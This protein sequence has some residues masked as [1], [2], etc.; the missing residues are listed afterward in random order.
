MTTT[1]VLGASGFIGGHVAMAALEQGWEV[2]GLRR[3]PEATGHLGKA[4]IAWIQGD[5][6]EPASLVS[7]FEEVEIVFHVAGY[8]PRTSRRVAQQVARAVN[9]T[10]AVLKCAR[11]G[12]VKRFVYVSSLSTIGRPPPNETRLPDERDHYLPGSLARSAYYECKYA[13]ESEVLRWAAQGSPAL[14]VNPTAVFGPGDVHRTLGGVL[15]AIAR[16]WGVASLP[17]VINAVDVRDVAG[18]TVR[19]ADAGRIGERTILGGHNLTIREFMT[20]VARL[21]GVK[22]PRFEIPPWALDLALFTGRNVPWLGFLDNHLA[23]IRHWQG[24]NC[25]KAFG[26]LGLQPRPLEST[27]RDALA[28]YR[29]GDRVDRN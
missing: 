9:Q 27:I 15:L 23:A 29:E 25:A 2:R 19:A 8:Y 11:D 16:G 28:W 1:L 20:L 17:A 7:A 24:Y 18:A 26:E 4:P 3:R 10:R 21:T 22:P 12:G 5:L 6:D 14:V 13:M